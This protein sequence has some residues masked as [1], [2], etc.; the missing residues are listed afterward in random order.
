MHP[1]PD[2]EIQRAASGKA[3]PNR[4]TSNLH[5]EI[6]DRQAS[7]VSRLYL[8]SFELAATIANLVWGVGR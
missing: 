6:A 8:V 7:R 5:D 3:P 2:P 1:L 4:N